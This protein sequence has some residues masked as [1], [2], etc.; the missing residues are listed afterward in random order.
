MSRNG[1]SGN[2]Q[3]HVTETPDVSHIKNID[4]THETS[5]VN[6]GTLL[7]FVLGLTVMTVVVYVLMWG[8]FRFFNRQAEKEPAPGPMTLSKEERLPPEP[9]LQGAKGFRVKLENGE[10]VDLDLKAPEAEYQ[11]VREQW[12]RQLNCK[13]EAA[14]AAHDGEM[15][16]SDTQHPTATTQSAIPGCVPIDVA[17][18]QILEQGLAARAPG[19]VQ[20]IAPPTAASS[21]RMTEKVEK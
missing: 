1:H 9:R 13:H 15:Q 19:T 7:K 14:S 16:H 20:D 10:S 2:G 6:V 11:V 17:M 21:G 4:V 12:E 18:R 3:K 5:D 8:L